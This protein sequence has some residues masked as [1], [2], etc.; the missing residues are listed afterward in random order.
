MG[1]HVDF[2]KNLTW[3]GLSIKIAQEASMMYLTV[4]TMLGVRDFSWLPYIKAR[5]NTKTR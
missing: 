5:R 4:L 1:L 3:K 2:F